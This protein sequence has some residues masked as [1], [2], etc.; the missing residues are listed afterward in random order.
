[1]TG[2]LEL[3]L[4]A[5]AGPQGPDPVDLA[6][7]AVDAGLS[8]MGL[9]DSPRLF[10]DGLVETGRILER[11]S[12]RLAGPCV[13]SLGL[14]HPTT[15]AGA[16][17]TLE[18]HFPGRVM[19]VVGRGESSVRN[20]GLPV[21]ALADYLTSLES[22]R[23]LLVADSPALAQRVL[24]AASGP[25]TLRATGAALGGALIDVGVDA[26]VVARAVAL[27]REERP[28]ARVWLFVRAAVTG[29]DD[30]A[31]AAA[32]PTLGSC[33][34]RMAAAP[35][36]YGIA[37]QELDAVRELAASHDYARHGSAGARHGETGSADRTVRDRFYLTGSPVEIA[38]RLE[39]LAGL[40]ITGVVLA[41]AVPGVHDRLADLTA[42]VRHG[43]DSPGD[44]P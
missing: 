22:L 28:D 27:T 17:R 43:L 1:V 11:T 7:Q 37:G 21:P 10:L 20:E 42:A 34:M 35:D 2:G 33:A 44:T 13:A 39:P 5:A 18:H 14:R 9:V 41:G 38:G 36:W 16:L 32:E 4:N 31:A 30:A 26:G 40:G 19:A 6:E 25:R 3:L 24:G 15:V 12:A 23:D 8:G 29:S